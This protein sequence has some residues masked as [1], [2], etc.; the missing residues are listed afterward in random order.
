MLDRGNDLTASHLDAEHSRSPHKVETA[1]SWPELPASRSDR[2]RD[3]PFLLLSS[4]FALT[5]P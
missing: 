2:T 5:D 4:H 1:V 3:E